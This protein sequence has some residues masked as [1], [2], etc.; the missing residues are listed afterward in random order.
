M[1]PKD[2][3]AE[4]AVATVLEYLNTH[5]DGPLRKVI[6]NVFSAEDHRIYN[7]ILN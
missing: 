7:S 2:K 6:F 3:A 5:R 4:I 1:F